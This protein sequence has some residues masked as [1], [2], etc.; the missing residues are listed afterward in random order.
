M[1][2]EANSDHQLK[3]EK[4]LTGCGA[5]LSLSLSLSLFSFHRLGQSFVFSLSAR[6]A[7]LTKKRDPQDEGF[8]VRD[9]VPASPPAD[10]I[11][12]WGKG[13]REEE[14]E[15]S[16]SLSLW[17]SLSANAFKNYLYYVYNSVEAE[18]PGG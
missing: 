10:N 11:T 3:W 18:T 16:L 13:R 4:V 2:W 6:E 1:G 5:S 14:E 15:G 8:C 9:P 12:E 17:L 7:G